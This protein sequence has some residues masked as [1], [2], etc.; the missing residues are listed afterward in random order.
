MKNISNF[1]VLLLVLCLTLPAR[2][3]LIVRDDTGQVL[4]LQRVQRI[5]SLA[6][7]ATE[8]L[9]AAG[10]G[11]QVVGVSDYSDYP[12]AARQLPRIG[13]ATLDMERIAALHPD[14]IVA[15]PDGMS[16]LQLQQLRK[17]QHPVYLSAPRR[18]DDIPAALE[19]MAVLS[20]APEQARQT[21]A[22]LRREL[23]Q[24]RQAHG[25]HRDKV[26]VFYQIWDKPLL[27]LNG[28]HI[29]S[30]AITTC[31]GENIFA[32]LPALTPSVSL[33]NVLQTNPDAIISPDHNHQPAPWLAEWK[34]WPH[35][36][37]VQK[38][39]LFSI[40]ADLINRPGPRMI[41]GTLALCKLLNQARRIENPL[42]INHD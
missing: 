29:V 6:P 7:H 9:F 28:Q 17:L 31:G 24:L 21:A 35:L 12:P 38:N 1:S 42:S 11:A 39:H 14:L 13:G 19:R 26:R 25:T 18:L 10:A 33:E 32:Q 30:D 5:V 2:A 15:W 37:A 23:Q 22:S 3:D 40:S 8:L 36:T 41:E 20:A 34:R 27:T 4:H 16:A